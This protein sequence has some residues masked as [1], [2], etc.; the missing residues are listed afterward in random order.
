MLATHYRLSWL[1]LLEIPGRRAKRKSHCLAGFSLPTYILRKPPHNHVECTYIY[2]YFLF[3]IF[4]FS[5]YRIKDAREG[6]FAVE[7]RA[8]GFV[9][10]KLFIIAVWT[11]TRIIKHPGISFHPLS[12]RVEAYSPQA[13]EGW[14]V[15][16]RVE[17]RYPWKF[18]NV[19]GTFHTHS[20]RIH[21][22]R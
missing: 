17:T 8:F 16:R 9:S 14:R 13:L 19:R 20:W 5:F 6:F 18:G 12:F 4:Y 3:F 10:P 1:T 21:R 2:F 15:V 11:L 7:V 22:A